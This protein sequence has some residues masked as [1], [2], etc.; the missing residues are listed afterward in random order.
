MALSFLFSRSLIIVLTTPEFRKDA[1]W[2]FVKGLSLVGK[3]SEEEVA[4]FLKEEQE[5]FL[6][7]FEERTS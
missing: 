2:F 3:Q 1:Q 5:E 4:Q 7:K 6:D